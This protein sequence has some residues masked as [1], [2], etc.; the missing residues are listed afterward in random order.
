MSAPASQVPS[1]P[2][3]QYYLARLIGME[4][5]DE[6]G[7]PMGRVED[8]LEAGGND[9][10]VVVDESGREFLVPLVG[11]IVTKVDEERG[12]MTVRPPEGLR[13]LNA[14]EEDGQRT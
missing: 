12:R 11:E 10:L 8:V 14:K 7:H 2:E 1:L 13:E 9:V 6:A 5:S 4:V 3:G